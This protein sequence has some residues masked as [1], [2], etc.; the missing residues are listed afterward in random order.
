MIEEKSIYSYDIPEFMGDMPSE[1]DS[2]HMGSIKFDDLTDEGKTEARKLLAKMQREYEQ[3][4]KK[5]KKEEKK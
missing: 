4:K 5:T 3:W 1:I 2:W